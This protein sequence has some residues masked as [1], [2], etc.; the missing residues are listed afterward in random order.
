MAVVASFEA[1]CAEARVVGSGTGELVEGVVLFG[2][3][4]EGAGS[5]GDGG[6]LVGPGEVGG[7][8]VVGIRSPALSGSGTGL[9]ESLVRDSLSTS[10]VSGCGLSCP[11]GWASLSAVEG[12][13]CGSELG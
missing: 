3:A 10:W 6:F 1:S 5:C 12:L 4:G 2:E 13:V 11:S 8:A 7:E 9:S